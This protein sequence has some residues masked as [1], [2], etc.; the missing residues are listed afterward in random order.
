MCRIGESI[1]V[2]TIVVASCGSRL[3]LGIWTTTRVE[4]LATRSRQPNSVSV[5]L[6]EFR[7]VWDAVL[8]LTLIRWLLAVFRV[9]TNVVP[10]PRHRSAGPERKG[11]PKMG[12]SMRF[13]R[14]QR[15][16]VILTLWSA[17]VAAFSPTSHVGVRPPITPASQSYA[18]SIIRLAATSTLPPENNKNNDPEVW[19]RQQRRQQL[20][21]A[22]TK[23]VNAIAYT[24]A[25]IVGVL[26]LIAIYNLFHVDIEA[27][28]ALWEYD[29][30]KHVPGTISKSA[31]A[32]DLLA[33]LPADAIHSYED[34]VAS[35][36]IYYKAWTS[37]VAYALGD[38]ISQV[39]QGKRWKNI[40]LPRSFRS[41]AAG[42]IGH[43]PLCHFW[44][45]TMETYLDF[46]GAWWATGLKVTADLTVWSIFLNAAYSFIIGSLQLRAPQDVW[47][48]VQAT[49]WPALRSAWRFW[50]FVHT[51]SFSH[52]VP[53]DLK[54][55]WVDCMEVVWVTILSKVANE[56]KNAKMAKD[57]NLE[58]EDVTESFATMPE[59]TIELTREAELK[60]PPNM[61]LAFELPKKV[62]SA[63]WP[64]IAMWPVLYVG[65]QIE[66]ALGLVPPAH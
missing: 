27:L 18:S 6:S 20:L 31:V 29:L 9:S 16:L 37:G 33:R 66:T 35:N 61:E 19:R 48:D 60:L 1:K 14:L 10:W 39:Y 13:L 42:F 24:N 36:P 59:T 32:V 47:K 4:P 41:G 28:L 56:D 46:D 50:P 3:K 23:R 55:L 64:L 44:L 8:L 34:L 17:R 62:L 53:L 63:C 58:L 57:P 26:V 11:A 15:W 5:L 38:F 25:A 7:E 65:Y 52:A 21:Q 51:V 30:G 2:S 49:S 54:L 40:D 12:R 22:R 45:L 43:G